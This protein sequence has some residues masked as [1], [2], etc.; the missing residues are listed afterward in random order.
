[1]HSENSRNTIATIDNYFVTREDLRS[2]DQFSFVIDYCLNDF[3]CINKSSS[4]AVM[5]SFF[6]H[7]LQTREL[8]SM[9]SM[10]FGAQITLRE[11]LLF[12]FHTYESLHSRLEVV[13]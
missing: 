12:S 3:S 6:V 9:N 1:M 13:D 2:L 7:F 11:L 4:V 10:V 5:D 8:T